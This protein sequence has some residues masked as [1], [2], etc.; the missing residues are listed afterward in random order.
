MQPVPSV[1][2]VHADVLVSGWHHWQSL[3]GLGTFV[4]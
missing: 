2:L 3:D 4:P 1:L